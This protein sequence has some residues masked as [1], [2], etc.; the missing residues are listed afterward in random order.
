MFK[1]RKARG[2]DY[3]NYR[4]AAPGGGVAAASGKGNRTD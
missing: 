2:N 3:E 4:H 1:M